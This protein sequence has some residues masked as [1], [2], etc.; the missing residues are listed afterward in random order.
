MS[1]HPLT[2]V[3]LLGAVHCLLVPQDELQIAVLAYYFII[4]SIVY[5]NIRVRQSLPVHPL[6]HVQMLGAVHCLL[7]PQD[8]LQIAVLI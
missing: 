7:V 2:H 4:S 3:Q 1:V 6:T 5:S 8:E